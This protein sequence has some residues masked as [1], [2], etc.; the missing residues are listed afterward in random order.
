VI[1]LSLDSVGFGKIPY[2]MLQYVIYSCNVHI[3]TR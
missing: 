1:Q 2:V 3:G